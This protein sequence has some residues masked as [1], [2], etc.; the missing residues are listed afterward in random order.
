[1]K[2]M[3]STI[4][5]GLIVAMLG[6]GLFSSTPS[7]NAQAGIPAGAK[8]TSATL[9]IYSNTANNYPVNVHRIT[10]SWT[11]LGVTW[12]NFNAS[13]DATV[14]DTLH[15]SAVTGWHTADITALMQEWV[16]GTFPNYGVLLEQGRTPY[17]SYYSSEY[18]VP[19]LRPYFKI[20][21]TAAGISNTC[22]TIQRPA[23]NHEE[24]FDSF[25]WDLNP[26]SNYGNDPGLYT[27]V[28]NEYLKQ[29]LIRFDFSLLNPAVSIVKSTNGEIASDPDDADV[30]EIKPGDPVTWTYVVTN[31]GQVRIANTAVTVTDDQNGVSPVF[32]QEISGNG[33]S[34]FDPGEVWSYKATGVAVDLSTPPAGVKVTQGVCTHNQTQPART[35]YVNQGT[36]TVPGASSTAKSSYCNPPLP[37]ISIAKY[38]NGYAAN[39]PD[40]ADVPEIKPGDPVTWTYVVTNTGEVA[41]DRSNVIVADDQTGVTPAFDHEINGNGDSVFNPGEVWLYKATG[42]AVDLIMP[43]AGVK[44]TQGVCTHNQTQPARTAYVNQGTASIPGASSTDKSSY[45]NPL[46]PG[47]SVAKY[48]N[49]QSASDPDGADVPQIKPG[50]PVT[51]TYVVTNTGNVPVPVASVTVADDQTGVTPAFDHEINGNGD[52]VFDP[53]EVWLYKA[54]DVAVD[55]STPPAGVKVTQGVCTHNQTQ[56]ARTAY[57]NQGTASIP[58]ASSTDKSSYC[59][60]LYKV[61]FPM[62]GGKPAFVVKPW[63][64]AVGFEDLPLATGANDWDYNDWI[65]DIDGFADFDVTANNGLSE[66]VFNFNPKARGAVFD[67]TFHIAIQGGTFGSNGTA[68]L[69]TYDQNHQVLSSQ[70]STFVASADND[71]VIFP[72][73]SDV[74]PELT[75]TYETLPNVPAKRYASLDITFNT[76]APFDLASY[77]FS[78]PHGG[79][80]FFDPYLYVH[81]T[82]EAIHRKDIRML[83]VP[84][85]IY[86][87]PEESIRI[88]QA[89]PN[90]TFIAGNPPNITFPS[91]WWQTYNHC[92]YDG[93]LCSLS[94]TPSTRM[95]APGTPGTPVV[96]P[97]TP[98]VTSP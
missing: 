51:W 59:N 96:T 16:D 10:A 50:D 9:Y 20:C 22:V 4:I 68:V 38:T 90:V 78:A 5:K 13:Y 67:H 54:T 86:K 92:V 42:I 25:I 83:T 11:E 89:Y 47:I 95:V 45:C 74:F 91:M 7:A 41:V 63:H 29:T 81:Y 97:G 61:Y 65:T 3:S 72:N 75:N 31:T 77:D 58:G 71:F 2:K 27:G 56:P 53:G 44:V 26:D 37:G 52:S 80:L 55:L 40:D 69:T 1:M 93:V 94:K 8:I 82:G 62:V 85:A 76:P 88:D 21:Y 87:W 18:N 28:I 98:T 6:I 49:G 23:A 73:T 36:V 84:N 35:A 48:T 12:N 57:V 15:P 39:D 32:D 66:I 14:I 43:P 46:L 19:S 79:G 60:P 33:D 64:V 70:S 30:P 34:V 24:V 17:T